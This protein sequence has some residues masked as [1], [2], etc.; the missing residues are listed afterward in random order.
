MDALERLT[1]INLDDLVNAFGWQHLPVPARLVRAMFRRTAQDFAGQMLAFDATIGSR[2]LEEAAC[3][4]ERLFVQDVRLYGA[5]L[6]PDG[7]T[8]MLAN[9]PGMTDTL[10]L[11]AALARPDLKIIA[12]D[13]PFLLSLPNL[14]RQLL[15]VTDEPLER[16]SLV[17]RVHRHLKAG[18]SI[19]TFPSGHTE[20][21]PA[22]YPGAVESLQTWTDSVGVF[23]RLAPE[24]AI[25]P[26]CVRNV[27]WDWAV[28]HP[29]ARRRNDPLDHM[30]LAS[31]FQLVAN[32][33]FK[34]RPV[35]VQIQVGCPIYA[36]DLGTTDTAV[37]H[38]A[39]LDEMKTLIECPPHGDGV[40][41]L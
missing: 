21:D 34:L 40:S 27:T 37:L 31:A 41:V 22:N 38:Q 14:A 35:T 16:V 5:E 23:V 24:T 6:L 8:L 7:P 28:N 39:V 32:V 12:L 20:P 13:R 3:L 18:G 30:L 17:R 11:L 2:G 26:I 15:Y 25:V 29:L 1:A 4:T 33:S 10:A 36:R 19:L 9:H